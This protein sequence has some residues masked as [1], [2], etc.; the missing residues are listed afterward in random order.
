MK[1]QSSIVAAALAV[2]GIGSIEGFAPSAA[3]QSRSATTSSNVMLQMVATNE[4]VEGE[5]RQR[6]TREVS[7]CNL[8]IVLQ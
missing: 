3:L 4:V 5:V 2:A 1:F 7:F 6:K 8:E